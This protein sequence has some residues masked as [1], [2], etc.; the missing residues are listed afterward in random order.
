MNPPMRQVRPSPKGSFRAALGSELIRKS[1][2]CAFFRVTS[3]S[4]A[5]VETLVLEVFPVVDIYCTRRKKGEIA[6]TENTP[7]YAR[8]PGQ[9]L[10]VE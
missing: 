1:R 4:S 10:T 8:I 9:C 3:Q 2:F 6:I 7:S 5:H